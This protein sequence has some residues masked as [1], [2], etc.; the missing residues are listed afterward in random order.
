MPL[1]RRFLFVLT[2]VGMAWQGAAAA[3]LAD[4]TLLHY[5]PGHGTQVEYLDS[6][7]MSYLWYPGNRVVLA[8]PW[9][10]QNNQI[11]Y[12]YATNTYNPVTKKRG[13]RWQCHPLAR[14]QRS[15]VEQVRGDVFGLSKSRNVPYVLSRAR[16]TLSKLA[17]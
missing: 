17:R 3:E 8:A 12:K 5:D 9:K 11:C 1:I 14:Y 10:L 13:G 7:G 6:N 16:T 15:L 2:L 4:S